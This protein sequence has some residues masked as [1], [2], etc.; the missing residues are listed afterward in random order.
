[1]RGAERAADRAPEPP[2]AAAPGPI[3]FYLPTLAGGGA[4]RSNLNLIEALRARGR[5]VEIVVNEAS[6]DLLAEVPADM[7]VHEL[8]LS[9]RHR[10]LLRMILAH[11]RIFAP[12]LLRPP[13]RFLK[14]VDDL[15]RLIARRRPIA[16]IASLHGCNEAAIAAALTVPRRPRVLATV[17]N[18]LSAQ[19]RAHPRLARK[20]LWQM[21]RLL[22]HADAVIAV[23]EGV[24]EDLARVLGRPGT[25]IVTIHNPVIREDLDE[26]AAQAPDH[27]WFLP[28]QPPV[29]LAAG[30]LVAQKN[31]PLLLEAF[32]RLRRSGE[33]DSRLVILGAGPQDAELRAR[34]AA[35]GIADAVDLP[36]FVRNPFAF[37]ARAG[38]FVLSSDHEGLPGVL[39]QA[40]ACGCPVVSTDCP[41]GPREVLADGAYGRLVPIGDAGAMAAAIAATLAAPPDPAFLRARGRAFGVAR[42]CEAWLDLIDRAPLKDCDG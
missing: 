28:G 33:R 19:L 15:A 34:A 24:A 25:P 21:R 7:P 2:P 6:G 3:L 12:F 16:L 9:S 27:P 23:S 14:Y 4:E 5:A 35:L 29:V 41:S 37:M 22:P 20:Q 36:G 1:M 31:F 38:V 10:G 11:P 17:R 30:R 8:Q 32:A 40:L 18:T 42:A 13:Q 39:I 26:Q